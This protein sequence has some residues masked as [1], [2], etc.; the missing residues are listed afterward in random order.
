MSNRIPAELATSTQPAHMRAVRRLPVGAEPQTDG[1]VHFRVWARD[2][3]RVAVVIDGRATPLVAEGAESGA[4]A[5]GAE[6]YFSGIVAEAREGTRYQFR[7]DDDDLLLPDPAS[8]WQPDGPHGPSVVVDPRRFAWTDRGWR[9]CGLEGQVLY[10]MHV[11]TFT[12]EGTLRAAMEQLAELKALGITVIELMPVAEFPGR[13][14]WG[15]DGVDWFAPTRLYGVPDD[16]RAFVDRAHALGLGVMLDVVYNHFGPDGNYL[17][18]FARD[19]FTDRY[20]NEWG[21]AI[22]YDGPHSGPVREFV[23]A[24]V[25]YWID[26]FHLDGFRLD[27]TQQIFDASQDHILAALTRRARETARERQC[28][29]LVIAENEKQEAWLMRAPGAARA[30]DAAGAAAGMDALWNDDLH[31]SAVVAL[32]GRHEAY[33]SDFRGTPQELLSCAKWGFLFQG[34]HYAWQ[35][36]PRG[37]PALDCAPAQFVCFIENHD[38]VANSARGWRLHQQTSPGR[39]RAMTGLLLLLPGTPLLF[40]GQE[41][42]SSRPFLFFADHQ[43]DLGRAVREGRADFLSQFKRYAQPEVRALLDDPADPRTFETCKLDF[44]ERELHAGV[45]RLHRDLLRLRRETPAFRSQGRPSKPP[46]P[47]VVNAGASSAPAVR[48]VGELSATEAARRPEALHD[49]PHRREIE[50]RQAIGGL[51]GAVLGPEALLL[52][53]FHEEGDRLVLLNLGADLP[54]GSCSDPLIAPPA[55]QEWRLIWSSDDPQ[56]GGDGTPPFD[57]QQLVLPAHALLVLAPVARERPS[58]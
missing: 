28:E 27:A 7:L 12:R 52:R 35:K 24:N 30:A 41:F 2:R 47:L 53:F 46:H 26:E 11:G 16:L 3:S 45:Y 6:G 55:G 56:Y 49:E 25:Q 14:G 40:Q 31:H 43:G 51:D 4:E 15:Y 57:A 39:F 44:A 9:G 32:T 23:L 37:E 1:G 21:E 48:V 20:A 8:R 29:C 38:Q 22:N 58:P 5:A 34:Q 42:A 18:L 33:Y 36:T 50:R 19:Y 10:E 17:K 54:L 13:F